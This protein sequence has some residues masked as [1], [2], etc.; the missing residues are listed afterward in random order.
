MAESVVALD[1]MSVKYLLFVNICSLG[2][3]MLIL[4]IDYFLTRFVVK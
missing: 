2:F 3:N 4:S 1:S